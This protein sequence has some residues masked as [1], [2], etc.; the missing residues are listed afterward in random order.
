MTGRLVADERSAVAAN[1]VQGENHSVLATNDK[2]RVALDG[3]SEVVPGSRNLAGMAGKQPT[4]SPNAIQL[5][6]IYFTIRVEVASERPARTTLG[7]ERLDAVLHGL[8]GGNST[9]LVAP[10][11][12]RF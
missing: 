10:H 4:S 1:V 5:E 2:D 7:D 6:A 3:E 8:T 12:A 9:P 11:N